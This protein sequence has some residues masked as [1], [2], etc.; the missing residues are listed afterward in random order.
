MTA[1]IPPPFRKVFFEQPPTE[2]E[3]QLFAATAYASDR[4]RARTEDADGVRHYDEELM[5]RSC[6]VSC[7]EHRGKM[8]SL[9]HSI[10]KMIVNPFTHTVCFAVPNDAAL[11]CIARHAPIVEVGAGSGYWAT[12]LNQRGVDVVAYDA[13]PPTK[14][15]NNR[16][17]D[18]TFGRVMKGVGEEIF[19]QDR[20][21][22]SK[23]LMLVWPT[24]PEIPSTWDV[25]CLERY[26]EG[27]GKTVIYVGER[28]SNVRVTQG[29]PSNPGVTAT[30]QFQSFL[31]MY[32]YLAEQ[33]TIPTWGNL[34]DDLTVW[35]KK[36]PFAG[37][38]AGTA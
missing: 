16:F 34:V 25:E 2:R 32:Y 3:M 4:G 10:D 8:A 20:A 18:F 17:C 22:C 6:L 36:A 28:S 21:L 13:E 23:A 26:C 19:V 7:G 14:E 24:S 31:H 30:R 15:H 35:K 29:S 5:R 1:R 33:V 38:A 11:N 9:Y 27:G 12:L 37:Q